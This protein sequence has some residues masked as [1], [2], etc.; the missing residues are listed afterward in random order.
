VTQPCPFLRVGTPGR[1]RPCSSSRPLARAARCRGSRWFLD[2]PCRGALTARATEARFCCPWAGPMT[3]MLMSSPCVYSHPRGSPTALSRGGILG[4]EEPDAPVTPR[5]GDQC[6]RPVVGAGWRAGPSRV[7][8]SVRPLTGA[9]TRCMATTAVRR[10]VKDSYGQGPAGRRQG[11]SLMQDI[12]SE[13]G[14]VEAGAR[15]LL[16]L[17]R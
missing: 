9:A 4:N 6:R 3:M 12:A 13:A 1:R 10:K 7:T 15:V 16:F 8:Q 5:P 11:R 2:R 14:A 17:L